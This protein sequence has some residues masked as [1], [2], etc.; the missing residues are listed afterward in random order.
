MTLADDARRLNLR[1]RRAR[2]AAARR[3]D[4]PPLILLTDEH[5][6]ADPSAAVARLPKGSAV[7]LRHYGVP[8]EARTAL[9]RELR[10]VTRAR[11][12][13]LLIAA[14]DSA[15]H[16]LA[17]RIEADGVHLPEW[18]VRNGAWR[19]LRGR[20]PGWLVTAAAHSP[21]ALRRAAAG[22]AD[23]VLLSPVF[24]TASHAG[25]RPLGAPR[26]AAWARLSPIP[27]YALGGIDARSA[28]RLRPTRA[29]GIAG[30]GGLVPPVDR[31]P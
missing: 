3:A 16:D 28:A 17:L 21:A 12:L 4:L 2:A 11:G 22:G 1:A 15:S 26:F 5:R 18:H 7:I 30:I 14:A 24:A 10:R 13:R 25:S 8:D 31:D 6:L 20:K 9:A 23:A 19:A 27:V 29:S